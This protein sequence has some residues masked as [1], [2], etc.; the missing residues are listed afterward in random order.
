MDFPTLCA[1]ALTLH[2]YEEKEGLNDVPRDVLE[3]AKEMWETFK[4]Y[5]KTLQRPAPGDEGW[6]EI[7]QNFLPLRAAKR[8]EL[9]DT[10]WSDAV[11]AAEKVK[12]VYD[13]ICSQMTALEIPK[14]EE[15]QQKHI[16]LRNAKTE[17]EQQTMATWKAEKQKQSDLISA[18]QDRGVWAR[19]E[20]MSQRYA[21]AEEMRTIA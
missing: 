1:S 13:D 17:E 18:S 7:M 21:G 3:A 5:C 4:E 8:E 11:N 12:E 9:T 20:S 2:G 10:S 6:R 15:R 14:H 16:E 19:E